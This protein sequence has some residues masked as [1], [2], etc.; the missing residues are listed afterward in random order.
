MITRRKV[1]AG[2]ILLA[3]TAGVAKVAQAQQVPAPKSAAD[4]PRMPPGTIMTK[5]FVTMVGRLAYVWG[6]PMV[7]QINRRASF[8]LV[9]EC[10][11]FDHFVGAADKRQW[12]SDAKGLG[13]HQLTIGGV[14]HWQVGRLLALKDAMNRRGDG[15]ACDK[16]SHCCGMG[17]GQRSLSR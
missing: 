4:V 9:P 11:S 14:L 10:R 16:Y 6:W 8:A 5:D 2:G 12:D 17:A 3:A 13:D 1:I 15:G 7:N